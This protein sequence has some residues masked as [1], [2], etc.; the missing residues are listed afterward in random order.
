MSNDNAWIE[1]NDMMANQ[2]AEQPVEVHQ[3]VIDAHNIP[4]E[5]AGDAPVADDDAADVD[6]DDA[7]FD[8][9]FRAKG[10]K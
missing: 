1:W 8:A 4:M 7:A 3:D 6:W 10:S 9:F 2:P 5:M